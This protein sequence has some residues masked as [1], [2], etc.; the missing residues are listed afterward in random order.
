MSRK[1]TFAPTM[2]TQHDLKECIID[3]LK[4]LMANEV[5]AK[6]PY[7]ARAYKKVIDQLKLLSTPINTLEDLK[8][9]QGIGK[10]IKEKLDTLFNNPNSCLEHN[11]RSK[12][13]NNL[14][15]VHGIGAVKA[16]ELYDMHHIRT[17]ADLKEHTDLL[18]D[19][20][21]LALKYVDD[22][23]KRIPRAEMLKHEQVVLESVQRI[24]PSIE[25]Q[26][27]GS[28]RRK[29]ASSGDIDVLITHPTMTSITPIVD[30]LVKQGYITDIFAKGPKKCLAVCKLK[31]HKSFRRIDLLFT[32][33][34]EFPFA[35]LYF[36]GSGPFNVKMRN[37]ALS[38]GLSL[39]EHGMKCSD[40]NDLIQDASIKEESDI[41][42]YLGIKYVAP[43]ERT[44]T[45]NIDI[46]ND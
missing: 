25:A 7:K 18:N 20:Q 34:T 9:I 12:A 23:E 44:D 2:K 45:V 40:S 8:N 19:K 39:N 15:K 11:L 5:A 26:L 3:R 16:V 27:T 10:S 4:T 21:K 43:E 35:L 13:I 31:R 6:Q 37:H 46:I 41:F 42:K 22:F 24:D 28:F 32:P 30:E 1:N 14:M 33:P 29:L 17:L 36:T 38:L